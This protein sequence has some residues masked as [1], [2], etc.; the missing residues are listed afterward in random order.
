M[1]FDKEDLENMLAEPS[2]NQYIADVFGAGCEVRNS[3]IEEEGVLHLYEKSR[4][5]ITLLYLTFL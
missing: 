1:A 4:K 5:S 3:G 2:A